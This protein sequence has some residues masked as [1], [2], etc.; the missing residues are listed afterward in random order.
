MGLQ[1]ATLLP[2]MDGWRVGM[3]KRHTRA[4]E[5]VQHFESRGGLN[6]QAPGARA[7]RHPQVLELKAQRG[8]RQ[9]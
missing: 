7:Q 4:P 3:T 5:R 9:D 6:A 8:E 1:F 2:V